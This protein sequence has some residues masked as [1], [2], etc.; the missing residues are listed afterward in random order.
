VPEENAGSD[1]WLDL[2]IYLSES[3]AVA[4]KFD[5][6]TKRVGGVETLPTRK[7][8]VPYNLKRGLLKTTRKGVDVSNAEGRMRLLLG[9]K[10]S[11]DAKMD[12]CSAATKPASPSIGEGLWLNVLTHTNDIAKKRSSPLLFP[13][14]HR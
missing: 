10:F 3:I 6:V 9:Y 14:W 4:N 11:F 1:D 8:V 2:F 12:N 5:P 13:R 7:H